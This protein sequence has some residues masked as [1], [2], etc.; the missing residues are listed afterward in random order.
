[1]WQDIGT[2]CQKYD[3]FSRVVQRKHKM[4]AEEEKYT[5]ESL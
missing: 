4:A 3:K 1:M 5:F 2:A